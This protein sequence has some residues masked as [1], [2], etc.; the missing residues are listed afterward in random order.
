MKT[1]VYVFFFALTLIALDTPRHA[2]KASPQ[3]TIK[4]KETVY[5]H[6]TIYIVIPGA[7]IYNDTR[8][9]KAKLNNWH[10]GNI[11][12]YSISTGTFYSGPAIMY[13]RPTS[14]FSLGYTQQGKLILFNVYL[15][16]K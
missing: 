6:D 4:V 7:P 14:A 16:I 5:V 15:R 13:T 12:G 8:A 11:Y 10:A 1:I 2:P 3:D 9:R